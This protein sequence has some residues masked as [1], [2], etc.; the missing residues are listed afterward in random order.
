M[1]LVELI[2]PGLTNRPNLF[3]PVNTIKSL[4]SIPLLAYQKHED[5]I[6]E[7]AMPW[8]YSK[9]FARLVR[10]GIYTFTKD[11]VAN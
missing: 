1:T 7:S 4:L 10:Q 8:N 11:K 5:S 3:V 6:V 9:Q 2:E